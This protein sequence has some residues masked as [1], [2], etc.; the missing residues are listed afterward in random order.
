MSGHP[1]KQHLVPVSYLNGFLS[2]S[3]PQE[4]LNNPFFEPGVWVTDPLL[5]GKWRLKSPKTICRRK[6]YYN[7]NDEV[8]RNPVVEQAL[9]LFETWFPQLR[10]KVCLQSALTQ[11]DLERLAIFT[12][13][14]F[15]RVENTQ[16]M[17][18]DAMNKA[19]GFTMQIEGAKTRESSQ[20]K[21]FFSEVDQ[22]GRRLILDVG[23][24]DILLRNRIFLVR[25]KPE[26][27]YLTCD[28]PVVHV[29]L[30]PDEVAVLIGD[31]KRIDPNASPSQKGPV[32]ILPITPRIVL[33]SS[34]FITSIESDSPYIETDSAN[35]VFAVNIYTLQNSNKLIIS[36]NK[37]AFGELDRIVAATVKEG[38]LPPEF[39]GDLLLVHT[40]RN[41]YWLRLSKWEHLTD[42]FAFLTPD[43]KILSAIH[44]DGRLEEIAVYVDGKQMGAMRQISFEYVDLEGTNLNIIRNPLFPPNGNEKNLVH[45]EETVP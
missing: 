15:I 43:L 21:D 2:D 42:R 35:A 7:L 12:M 31:P 22:S 36:S 26:F 6:N 39:T 14:M 38:L 28:N 3:V 27:R 8:D 23:L 16:E 45:V 24:A 32:F 29:I 19:I 34:Q 20:Y 25:C 4:Y 44:N 37:Y 40:C 17:W 33:I 10:E 11:E 30:H 18:S 1:K 5:S 13:M 9:G 41:R